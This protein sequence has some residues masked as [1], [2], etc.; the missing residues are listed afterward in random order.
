MTGF[1]PSENGAMPSDEPICG[2]RGQR[3]S[4]TIEIVVGATVLVLIM[5]ILLL[6]LLRRYW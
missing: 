3:C 5:L 6:W 1:W 2:Y 4:Y